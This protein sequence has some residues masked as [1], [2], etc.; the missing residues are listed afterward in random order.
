MLTAV[1]DV[2]GC[3]P[4]PATY[5]SSR[6]EAVSTST[7]DLAGTQLDDPIELFFQRRLM[8]IAGGTG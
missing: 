7:P 6:G 5:W 8:H 4:M 3:S 2:A 1:G